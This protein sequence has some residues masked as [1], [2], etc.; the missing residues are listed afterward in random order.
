MELFNI[1]RGFVDLEVS[2]LISTEL[3][4]VILSF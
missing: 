3:P 4:V 1:V 2:Y